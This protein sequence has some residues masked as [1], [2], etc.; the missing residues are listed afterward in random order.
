MVK[1]SACLVLHSYYISS[2]LGEEYA[3]PMC[4]LILGSHTC[5][6]YCCYLALAHANYPPIIFLMEGG[7]A[8]KKKHHMQDIFQ[9]S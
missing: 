8:S 1:F 7:S 5:L 9:G 6:S 3:G 2:Q 4:P